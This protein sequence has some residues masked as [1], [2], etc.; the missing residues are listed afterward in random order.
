MAVV[1]HPDA[2]AR[3]LNTDPRLSVLL[4]AFLVV[5]SPWLLM[6]V[7]LN[8]H[9]GSVMRAFLVMFAPRFTMAFLNNYDRLVMMLFPAIAMLITDHLDA[10]Q[11][12]IG[13]RNA[14]GKGSSLDTAHEQ[15]DSTS[16]KR[17]RKC[18][19]IHSPLWLIATALKYLRA[20]YD[21]Q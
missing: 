3:D 16:Q 6:T 10:Q 11:A 12:G 8:N 5:L 13:L 17:K 19:H 18:V 4:R 1:T 9:G 14:L 7:L 15:P 21:S 20:S 2:H